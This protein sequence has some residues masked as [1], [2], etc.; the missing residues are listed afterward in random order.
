MAITW[1]PAALLFHV[2][3]SWNAAVVGAVLSGGPSAADAL[4]LARISAQTT[5][6]QRTPSE[7]SQSGESFPPISVVARLLASENIRNRLAGPAQKLR[8]SAQCP[9]RRKCATPALRRISPFISRHQDFAETMAD[10]GF[11]LTCS[12]KRESNSSVENGKLLA[13][14]L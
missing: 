9:A 6:D 3:Q 10:N 1:Q 12:N 5:S 7:S 13:D 4:R 8:T 11:I 2:R 14:S